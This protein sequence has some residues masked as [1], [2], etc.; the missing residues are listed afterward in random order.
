METKI[1]MLFPQANK[2]CSIQMKTSVL[3]K[4]ISPPSLTMSLDTLNLLFCLKEQLMSLFLEWCLENFS[5]LHLLLP[6]YKKRPRR[7]H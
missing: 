1:L 5:G 6:K 3:A 4:Q 7:V 2:Y